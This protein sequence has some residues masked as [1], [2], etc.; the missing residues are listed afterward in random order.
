MSTLLVKNAALL[1]TFDDHR[2]EIPDGG[3]FVRDGFIE[4]IGPSAELPVDIDE[5]L[6]LT[7]HIVLPGLINTHHHF[8]QTLTR[9]VPG[10]QNANLLICE[11]SFPD[12][13]KVPG[14]LSPSAAGK[15]A[16]RANVAQLVLT[17]F[18]PAC[19]QADVNKECR[20]AYAGEVILA[21]DLLQLRL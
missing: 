2:R 6:D 9:A 14:H 13:D 5:V 7:G 3:F 4:E 18:Y 16:T 17:H 1:A 20:R 8:Y 21:K 12:A 15:I 10:A 19:D 11:C